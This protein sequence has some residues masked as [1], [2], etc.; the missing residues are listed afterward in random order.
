MPVSAI[1]MLIFGCVVLYGGLIFCL[2]RAIK[3]SRRSERR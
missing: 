2:R 3:S 1:V